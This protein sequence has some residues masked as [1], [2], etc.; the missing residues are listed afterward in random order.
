MLMLCQCIPSSTVFGSSMP[1]ELDERGRATEDYQGAN[2][3][4]QWIEG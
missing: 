4:P 2:S 3:L 1:P